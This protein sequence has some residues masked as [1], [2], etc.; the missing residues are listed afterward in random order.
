MWDLMEIAS[1]KEGMCNKTCFQKQVF[2]DTSEIEVTQKQIK[3]DDDATA[4]NGSKRLETAQNGSKRLKTAQNGKAPHLKYMSYYGFD[5][6]LMHGW[7]NM[8]LEGQFPI[9][10]S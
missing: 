10:E 5:P 3:T 8:G 9:E 2:P 4:R 1:T 6:P 7:V